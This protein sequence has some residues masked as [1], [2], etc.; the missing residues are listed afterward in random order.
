MR[1]VHLIPHPSPSHEAEVD[2]MV[3]EAPLLP[4]TNQFRSRPSSLPDPRSYLRIAVTFRPPTS[5]GHPEHHPQPFFPSCAS[6]TL[7]Q[8]V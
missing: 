3:I 6:D 8:L 2:D 7:T 5:L 4:H 1:A